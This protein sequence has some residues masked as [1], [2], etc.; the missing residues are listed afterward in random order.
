MYLV[1]CSLNLKMPPPDHSR[2]MNRTLIALALGLFVGLPAA[3]AQDNPFGPRTTSPATGPRT[4]QNSAAYLH[5]LPP[6]FTEGAPMGGTPSVVVKMH[7]IGKVNG[8][9]V[10]K[11]GDDFV[12]RKT[13]LYEISAAVPDA[14]GAAN[15]WNSSST[16]PRLPPPT[17]ARNVK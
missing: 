9:Y 8:T 14:P 13:P 7:F 17:P 10:Y 5:R 6:R 16:V 4:P 3:H 11:S 1:Q 15:S 12:Y 2:M